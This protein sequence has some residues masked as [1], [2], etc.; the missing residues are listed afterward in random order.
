MFLKFPFGNCFEIH[1]YCHQIIQ[2]KI[3]VAKK[4]LRW[5]FWVPSNGLPLLVCQSKTKSGVCFLFEPTVFN[6]KLRQS[7]TSSS[8]WDWPN[9]FCNKERV[10]LNMVFAS[11]YWPKCFAMVVDTGAGLWTSRILWLF[12]SSSSYLSGLDFFFFFFLL[13]YN[14]F[15]SSSLFIYIIFAFFVLLLLYCFLL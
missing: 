2:W 3:C 1:I 14:F 7:P 9:P 10:T 8:K 4:D 5:A 11:R 12:H 13:V 6:L 15:S